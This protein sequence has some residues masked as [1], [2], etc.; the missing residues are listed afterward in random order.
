MRMRLDKFLANASIGTRSEVKKM[1]RMGQITVDGETVKRPEYQV[2]E[3]HIVALDGVNIQY[4]E[5]EYYM[6]NKPAGVVSATVDDCTTVVE[7]IKETNHKDLFPVGRLD[8]DTEGLL[9][10]TNDGKL[11]HDLLS[12]GK[13]VSKTYF[14]R[15]DGFVSEDDVKLFGEGVDIGDDKLT[16]PAS[17]KDIRHI[18]DKNAQ[19]TELLITITEGR[20]H[21]IKRM[22]AKIKKPVLYLKRI[23]MG[24]LKLDEKLGLG[25]YRLLSSDELNC[26][27][28]QD[29]C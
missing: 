23:E 17:L 9:V 19:L 18:Q 2:D 28:G 13:H 27:K 22:F 4:S 5:Y 20:Y 12:P 14:V 24:E 29:Q 15:V 25:E 16:K 6:L 1:I 21:Q 8:K 10:I 7:L 26:L 11:A 3:E